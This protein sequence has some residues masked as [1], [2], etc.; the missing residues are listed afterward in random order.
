MEYKHSSFFFFFNWA[1][2]LYAFS[3]FERMTQ[4][5]DP[6]WPYNAFSQA[7]FVA[8]GSTFVFNYLCSPVLFN[9]FVPALKREKLGSNKW[10]LYSLLASTVHAMVTAILA[11]YILITGE[12]SED[13]IFSSSPLG[14]MAMQFGLGY[15]IADFFIILLNSNLQN[16]YSSLIHHGAI[17]AGIMMG[18]YYHRFMFFIV[19]RFI[20]EYSTP[21]VNLRWIVYNI[22]DKKSKL[23]L[24]ASIAMTLSFFLCRIAVIPWHTY[25][26]CY[27][28]FGSYGL[29]V[30]VYLNFYMLLNF[31]IFD[32]LNLFWFYK[33]VRGAYKLL[34]HKMYHVD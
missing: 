25:K 2:I 10:Y 9:V 22:G 16:L 4:Y 26:L 24:F 15:S 12:L 34:V 11:S 8:L 28:L 17:V 13:A 23:Y 31:F 1:F 7:F 6:E 14:C 19:Y 3:S 20:A 30:P 29:Q 33:I 5:R 32:I 21:W 18:L 27:V